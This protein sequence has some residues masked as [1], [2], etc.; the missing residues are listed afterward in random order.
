M[1]F[2]I[3]PHW[4]GVLVEVTFVVATRKQV[5]VTLMVTMAGPELLVLFTAR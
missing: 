5:L 4:P 3:A 2:G 1:V